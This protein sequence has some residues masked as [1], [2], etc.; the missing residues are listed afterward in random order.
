MPILSPKLLTEADRLIKQY[1]LDFTDCI[2]IVT[3][4]HGQYSIL[5]GDSQSILITADRD[6]AKAARSEGARVWECTSEP[7][8]AAAT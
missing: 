5:I 6:L 1:N 3:V 7:W 8:P 2:Q 4:L